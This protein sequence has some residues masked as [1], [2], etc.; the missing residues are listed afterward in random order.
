MVAGA[1]EAEAG[2]CGGVAGQGR[3]VDLGGG[4]R[5]RLHGL[6]DPLPAVL[7]ITDGP[8]DAGLGCV[9]QFG[10]NLDQLTVKI[11][12]RVGP[13][14]LGTTSVTAEPSPPGQPGGDAAVV[15]TASSRDGAGPDDV[16]AVVLDHSHDPR[17]HAPHPQSS[18]QR[19]LTLWHYAALGCGR[20]Q[21]RWIG[22]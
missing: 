20:R 13:S 17:T 21:R 12:Q 6:G 3:G 14:G 18:W 19:P 22:T 16:A 5:V 15:V 8:H 10:G 4:L 9:G 1:A 7:F 2:L 11:I